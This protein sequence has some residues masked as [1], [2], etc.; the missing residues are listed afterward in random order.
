MIIIDGLTAAKTTDRIALYQEKLPVAVAAVG[1]TAGE[2]IVV[3]FMV[4]DIW[5]DLYV[6]GSKVTLTSTDKVKVLYAPL[7]I[8][9]VK[10]VT[11]SAVSVTLYSQN[12]E[13][14]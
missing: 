8:R 13:A 2:E 10:G 12:I 4:N 9:L 5:E 3:Q 7:S 11:V 1:L 6:S 14:L